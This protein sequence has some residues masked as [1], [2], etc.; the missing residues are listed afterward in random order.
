MITLYYI[1]MKNDIIKVVN[2]ILDTYKEDEYIKEKFQKFMLDHLP[3]QVLQWK[4]DQQR[5]LTRN[6]RNGKRTRRLY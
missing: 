3:N 1:I 6:E 5:R 2:T 4:N